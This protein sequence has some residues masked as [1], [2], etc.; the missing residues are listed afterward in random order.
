MLSLRP[1]PRIGVE[2]MMFRTRALPVI[3]LATLAVATLSGCAGGSTAPTASP[4]PTAT[5]SPT[6]TPTPTPEPE[7]TETTAPANLPTDCDALG[8]GSVREEAVGDLTLQGDGSGLTRPAPDGATLVLG[9]EWIVGDATGIV[10]LISTAPADAVT[11][12]AGSL[13]DEGYTC[14]VSDDFGA[15]YCYLDASTPDTEESI[16]ARDDVWIY[17]STSNRNGRAFLSDIATQIWG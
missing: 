13:P 3:V 6:P 7:P 4:T 9:C 5:V 2:S 8:S 10:V 15:T 17:M 1:F 16:T 11:A 14:G 12:A